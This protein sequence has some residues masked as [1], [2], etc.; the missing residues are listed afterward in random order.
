MRGQAWALLSPRPWAAL[1]LLFSLGAPVALAAGPVSLTL[2]DASRARQVPVLVHAPNPAACATR[3]P[4]LLFGTGYRATPSD[5]SFLLTGLADAGFLVVGIQHDLEHDP[6]MPSTGNVVRDRTPAWDRGVATVRFVKGELS[7]RFPEHDWAEVVLAGHSQGGDIGARLA[8]QKG[9]PVRALVTLDNRRVPLPA[10]ERLPVLSIRSADQPADPGVL[11]GDASPG[12]AHVCIVR[13][14]ATR[15]DDMN[16]AAQ[17]AAK[18]RMIDIVR[19]FL[20]DGRCTK[21]G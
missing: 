14:G 3:C 6:P 20:L 13:L 10:A 17:P 15:H 11:P 19:S 5:Y 1:P 21:A 9:L 18:A 2:E 12:R 8:A 4:V 16:D 7:R